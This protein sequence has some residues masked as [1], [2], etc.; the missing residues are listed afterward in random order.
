[1]QTV[2]RSADYLMR[3]VVLHRQ[4]TGA[5]VEFGAI[6][7]RLEK[8]EG[9]LRDEIANGDAP[10]GG[11]LE[12]YIIDYH[13]C[14]KGYFS[15]AADPVIAAALEEPEGATVYGR[16]NELHRPG[17]FRVRRHRRGAPER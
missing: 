5:P 9:P 7:I 15:T 16:C 1:M 12:K 4:D 3:Q 14:P 11:L 6:G 8:F 13:S 17:R 10:L 2:E